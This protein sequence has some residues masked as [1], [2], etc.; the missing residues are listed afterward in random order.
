MDQKEV[1]NHKVPLTTIREI[2]PHPNADRLEVAI[3]YGFQVVTQ[4]GKSKAGDQVAYIPIDS[5]LPQKLEDYL[6]PPGSKIDRKSAKRRI[7]QIRI[8]GLAS[9]GMIVSPTDLWSVYGV[10]IDELEKDYSETLEITKYEPPERGINPAGAP[11]GRKVK[12]DENPFFH[13]YNGLENIKWYPEK[14]KPEEIVV[15]QEKIHGTNARAAIQPFAANT[16]WKKIKRLFRLAPKYE[17]CFGSNNVQ[18]QEKTNFT[19]FYGNDVYGKVFEK[20]DVKNKLKPGESIYG[21][22]YGDGIQKNYKYGC[23]PGEHKFVLFDVKVLTLGGDQKWLSPDQVIAFAKERGFDMVPEIYRGP[24]TGLEFVKELTKGPSVLCPDQKIRE[25][26][27][28]KAV[29]NYD[30]FG[31]KR[32]LKVVSEAYLDD[33]SNTDFH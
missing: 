31:N 4:K 14:F 17:Y 16:L 33:T 11:G 20:L 13:K 10:R 8:R 19:G 24:F 25:G 7:R 26:V 2:Q 27:V 1:V 23:K 9:Q 21:E 32:A 3:V 6:F 5:V 12:A 29:D 28:I 30:E 15:A 22:I 18:I